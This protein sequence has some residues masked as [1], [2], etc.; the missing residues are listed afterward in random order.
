MLF[1]LEWTNDNNCSTEGPEAACGEVEAKLFTKKSFIY[2][3]NFPLLEERLILNEFN[4]SQAESRIFL[5]SVPSLPSHF[6]TLSRPFVRILQLPVLSQ[7]NFF[8]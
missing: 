8:I 3:G 4:I 5:A 1:V 7:F 6:Y 2:Q